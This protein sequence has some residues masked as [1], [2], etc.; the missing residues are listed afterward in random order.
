MKSNS[1]DFNRSN[2]GMA[3]K[4]KNKKIG[5]KKKSSIV[6]PP[7]TLAKKIKASQKA[8]PTKLSNQELLEAYR[9][10]L[11]ARLVDLKTITLYK[12]NKCH[13]QIG[14]AGHECIQVATAM[15]MRSAKDWFYPY[16]R[17]MALVAALGMTNEELFMNAM[18]KNDDPNSHGRQMPM[19]YGHKDLNIVN[20]SSP[21][22]TQFLQAVGCAL[23]S[24]RQGLQEVVYVSAGEGTCAQGDFH[25][26][27][28][29]ASRDKLPVIFV[30]QNN[31]YAISVPLH[32]QLANNVHEMMTGYKNLKC[33]GVDGTDI[34]E[35]Y[36]VMTQAYQRALNGEGPCLVEAFVPR[37]QSHSISDNHLKYRT[38]EDLQSE[39]SRC[40]IG[41]LADYLIKKKIIKKEQIDLITEE[42]KAQVDASAEWA[43]QQ[44]E[45]DPER[46]VDFTWSDPNP[47]PRT[48]PP[49]PQGESVYMVDALNH[50]LDEEMARN[51]NMYIFGQD[52]AHGKGG[53]F[54]VTTGLTAKYGS[55]RVFNSQLAES[56]IAG[57]AIGMA[58]RGLK[59]VA[60]IQFGD[61][62]WTAMMQIRNELAMMH[63]RSGG[64]FS[65]P[66]VLR[67]P[68][69][70]YIHGGAY[71]SQC[72]EATFSH[73]P[74]LFVV[75]PS[76]AADAKG[77]LKS[78]IR[79]NNPVLFLEHKGLYRQVYAKGNEGDA[80]YLIPL[81]KAR[82][83][84]EGSDLTIVAWG[85]LVQKAL[86]AAEELASEG[87][88]VEVIDLRTIVP[89]DTETVRASVQKTGRVLVAH[90]DVK[91]MGFGAEVS[92]WIVDNCFEYLDAPIRRIGAAESGAVPHSATL[93][94]A[95]LPQNQ[96]VLDA[97]RD[98]LSY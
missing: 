11:R 20:Q 8:K 63:Y 35:S 15:V 12:Q 76:N 44:A 49:Y 93:E 31:G 61:Y 38:Q 64:D 98:L 34:F 23:S 25:E 94:P 48:E 59:P 47:E 78:S 68:V 77:L 19:H 60:E 6:I 74:G 67:I 16:Y 90:E 5:S 91:F 58:T 43:D 70:G 14:V 54:T 82:V 69:G 89:F 45:P 2:K 73:F 55:E 71:H 92:A 28:N 72:I 21:T 26:A 4:V 81:G 30:I 62:V 96:Q 17:D 36:D 27:L 88:S 53:V 97:A 75:M 37:L 50:A 87:K 56:S 9:Q 79:C 32:E 42:I 40:P 80:D 41:K 24:V 13:F 29:W 46:A 18:N 3:K 86:W 52:V 85:Y 51:P 39:Q 66:A 84:R 1:L 33:F 65:A 7:S 83:A 10:M 57:V 95:I 22:G